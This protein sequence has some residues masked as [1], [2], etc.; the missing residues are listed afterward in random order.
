MRDLL[1][2]LESGTAQEKDPVRRAQAA[3]RRDMP[4][5]FY[6]E[7]AVDDA[8][9]GFLIRLDGRELK[10]PSRGLF[11]LPSRELAEAA[12]R[13]WDAQT[14]HIDPGA[15]PLTRILNT[16]LDGVI[17]VKDEVRQEILAYGGTDLLC[18]RADSPQG[19]VDAQNAAWSPYLA[20]IE[21]AHGARFVL[22]EGVMHVEQPEETTS[23]LAG[24][25]AS[26]D[27]AIVLSGLH[28]VTG[29]TGSLV[30]SLAVLEGEARP[31]DAWTAAHV[32]EDWNISQWG[33][34]AEATRRRAARKAEFDS[35]CVAM[36]SLAQPSA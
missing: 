28:V 15:M 5:R 36:L 22:A 2:D 24:L 35:A 3:F 17:H 18:Y 20:W 6:K 33:E 32:D 12:A 19:L 1:S 10:T 13:E 7:V 14:T 31:D 27:S 34:D 23:I 29:L 8:P 9:D 16:A 26:L 4:K 25:L 21:K 30:L 11:H